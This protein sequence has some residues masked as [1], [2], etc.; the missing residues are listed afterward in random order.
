MKTIVSVYAG[1]PRNYAFEPLFSGISAFARVVQWIDSLS[2]QRELHLERGVVFTAPECKEQVEALVG[3]CRIPVQVLSGDFTS[4]LSF[5]SALDSCRGD[6][7]TI[8]HC[9]Y[10][11]PFYDAEL[12]GELFRFHHKYAAE[13]TFA[14]GWPEGLAPVVVNGSTV[15]ILKSLAEGRDFGL[16]GRDVFFDVIRDDINSFEVET[17]MAS[18]DMRQ[19]RLDFSCHSREGQLA[20]LRIYQGL[21]SE[22]GPKD[23][24]EFVRSLAADR[25]AAK[26]VFTPGVLRTVPAFYNVQISATCPGTCTYCPY[27]QVYQETFNH[28]PADAP[29]KNDACFMELEKFK[30]LVASMAELS[31]EAVV[32]LSLWGEPLAHPD[33]L[34][35]VEVVLSHPGL[36]VL[37]ETDGSLVT[38]GLSGKVRELAA[39]APPRTNSYPPVIWIVSL[40]SQDQ[41]MYER[42]RGVG[43]EGWPISFDR[44]QESFQI[45]SRDFP[46]ASYTQ[47]V[48]TT[49]NEEQLEDFYRSRKDAGGLII[50]KYDSFLDYLPDRQVT[51]LSPVLRNPCWHQRRDMVILV[52]GGVPACREF[53]LAGDCGNVFRQPLREIWEKGRNMPFME[54]CE[55]CDEYY[56][57]NF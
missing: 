13:Y 6:C 8:I 43:K 41:A 28:P 40:D 3:N 9:R 15:A 20:C 39:A 47:F 45:L 19:Y 35:F 52:D 34:G 31:G 36:S 17:L 44:A 25:L 30:P 23:S 53:L 37:V 57:F 33:F 22:F 32:S 46:G 14:E 48:R 26:A 16:V 24:P 5:L 10:S 49:D 11:C 21:L 29:H 27:P 51:D 1:S 7:T 12:T 42:M 18:E 38:G 55:H 2:L 4:V 56:T 54:Q 50:Q